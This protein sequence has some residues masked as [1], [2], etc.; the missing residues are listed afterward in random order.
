MTIADECVACGKVTPI[1]GAEVVV[2]RDY[3]FCSAPCAARFD[4]LIKWQP[5]RGR[6][7]Q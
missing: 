4:T 2:I 6:K 7:C 5:E 1:D 3:F